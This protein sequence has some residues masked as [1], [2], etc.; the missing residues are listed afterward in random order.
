MNLDSLNLVELNAR[1]VKE[2]DGGWLI[3]VA[4]AIIYLGGEIYKSSNGIGEYG[5]P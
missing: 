1:E 5:R 4:L 2:V 3:P